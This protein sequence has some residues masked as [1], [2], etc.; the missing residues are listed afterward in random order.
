MRFPFTIKDRQIQ[1]NFDY[2]A[3][4]VGSG[5]PVYSANW[6]DL[7]SSFSPLY[8][9]KALGIAIISGVVV[10]S[11]ATVASEVIATVPPGFEA[12]KGIEIAPG[13][14]SSAVGPTRCDFSGNQ[15]LFRSGYAG[16][17][18]FL[19]IQLVYACER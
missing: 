13:L 1:G 6:S 3:G 19:A 12:I 18:G 4:K 14:I 2:L 8:C 10:K 17:G 7:G 11:T 5:V 9:K 15:L 16:T